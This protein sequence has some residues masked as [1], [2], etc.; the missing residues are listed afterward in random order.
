MSGSSEGLSG[1]PRPLTQGAMS[2]SRSASLQL[3]P[4]RLSHTPS[5]S[6]QQFT[7]HT[8]FLLFQS[9]ARVNQGNISTLT[10]AASPG[11][12]N[13]LS[14]SSTPPS[15]RGTALTEGREVHVPNSA[16][17]QNGCGR[18]H[19]PLRRPQCGGRETR[20][21]LRIPLERGWSPRRPHGTR[22]SCTILCPHPK[23][24][25]QPPSIPEAGSA[26]RARRRP[27]IALERGWSPG[28]YGGDG[29]G[30]G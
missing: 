4:V 17:T 1:R 26:L 2:T 6:L 15:W 14:T 30:A 21:R 29:A 23:W 16:L 9:T 10:S 18:L 11:S 22:G 12:D 28:R 8:T 7:H 19:P 25:R 3:G 24:P 5:L 27:R 13:T 20:K